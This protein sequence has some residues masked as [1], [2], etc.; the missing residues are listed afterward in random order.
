MNSQQFAASVFK[1]LARTNLTPQERQE[2]AAAESVLQRL[3]QGSLVIG[4]PQTETPK[5]EKKK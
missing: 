3:A 5:A 1:F 4:E 2:F